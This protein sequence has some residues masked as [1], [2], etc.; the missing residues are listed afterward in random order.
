MAGAMQAFHEI[1]TESNSFD[2]IYDTSSLGSVDIRRV[3]ARIN[4]TPL[5]QLKI[6]ACKKEGQRRPITTE[7]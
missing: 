3:K 1:Y 6:G 4:R 5:A 2:G 7:L